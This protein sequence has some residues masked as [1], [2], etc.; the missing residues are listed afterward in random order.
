[1]NKELL[2]EDFGYFCDYLQQLDNE[3]SS[4]KVTIDLLDSFVF[5]PIDY[6]IA[7]LLLFCYT[8]FLTCTKLWGVSSIILQTL[9]F[10][11]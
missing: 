8:C 1:V 5:K 2:K 6:F 10:K 9:N 3:I 4:R 11:D 7:S